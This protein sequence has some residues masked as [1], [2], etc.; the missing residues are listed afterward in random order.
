MS[1]FRIGLLKR[2]V[3]VPVLVALDRLLQP[4]GR[5]APFSPSVFTLNIAAGDSPPGALDGPLFRCPTC[6]GALPTR[7]RRAGL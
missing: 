4:T 5:I 3:P 2:A 6:G 1:Y 7:G